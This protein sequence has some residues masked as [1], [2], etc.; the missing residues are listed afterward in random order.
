M[1]ICDG[2]SEGSHDAEIASSASSDQ[3]WLRDEIVRLGPW[4]LDVQV[5]SEISTRVYLEEQGVSYPSSYGKVH[6]HS[7][8]VFFKSILGSVFPSGMRNRSVLDCACNC[9]G[10]LF[11][12]KELGAGDCLGFDIRKHWIDQAQFLVANRTLPSDRMRFEVCDLYA[13]EAL[14][15]QPF[16]V[17]IFHGIFYHLP[18]P[19]R[20]LKIVADLTRELLFLNTATR[21]GLSDGML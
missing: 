13:V 15:L 18:D 1:P 8:S 2:K 12:A 16:D 9:G 4:H 21:E 3:A 14:D 17:T 6:F 11:C 5:T 20:G 10:L 7:P 19:I